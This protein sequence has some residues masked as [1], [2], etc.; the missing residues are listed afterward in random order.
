M[1]SLK[2]IIDKGIIDE[3]DSILDDFTPGDPGFGS[4]LGCP[5]LT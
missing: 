1:R 5:G 3:I 2:A 4:S